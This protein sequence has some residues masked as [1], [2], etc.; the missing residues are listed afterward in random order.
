M[1]VFEIDKYDNDRQLVADYM[2]ERSRV[3]Q[4]GSYIFSDDDFDEACAAL[5]LEE[6]KAP[7]YDF[8]VL[9]PEIKAKNN[10]I[11]GKF[12]RDIIE[13]GMKYC[14]EF[15]DY[16]DDRVKAGNTGLPEKLRDCFLEIYRE[17]MTA[18]NDPEFGAGLFTRIIVRLTQRRNAKAAYAAIEVMLIHFFTMCEVFPK[19]ILEQTELF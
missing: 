5:K 6:E 11:D 4:E 19:K 18:M 10:H 7:T 15:Q 13:G 3:L 1:A 9:E 12:Y 17:E 14:H 2:A 16:L 8:K